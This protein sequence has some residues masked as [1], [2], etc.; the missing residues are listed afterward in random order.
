MPGVNIPVGKPDYDKTLGKK[1]RAGLPKSVV[2]RMPGAPSET[3]QERTQAI[4]TQ[5]LD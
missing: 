4:H 2:N 1:L 5:F 3:T